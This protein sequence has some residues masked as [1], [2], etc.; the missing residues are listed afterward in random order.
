MRIRTFQLSREFQLILNFVHGETPN[1]AFYFTWTAPDRWQGTIFFAAGM[2]ATEEVSGD[3][4]GDSVKE[5]LLPIQPAAST[6]AYYET[7]LKAG[8]NAAPAS[9][10]HVPLWPATLGLLLWVLGTRR[11]WS[12]PWV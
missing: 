1:T 7:T 9:T 8:C 10:R 4:S 2:V 12:S 5:M 6:K 3:P 11:R